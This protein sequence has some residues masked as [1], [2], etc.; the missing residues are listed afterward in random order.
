MTAASAR[1]PDLSGL[2]DEELVRR[3]RAGETGAFAAVMQR[4]NQRLYRVARAM[5][6]D[7]GE[8]ED[9][10][11]AAYL[12]AFA[13]LPGFRG[14]AAL[15]TWLTRIVLN[16]AFGRV[17]GRR[18]TDEL[19]VLETQD[20]D[21]RARLIMF[22]GV[23]VPADPEAAAAQAEIRRLL[24][25]AIDTL[26]DPFRLVFVMRELE[27]MSVEETSAQLGIRPETVKTR[28]HR[29]RRLLRAE[30]DGRLSSA[31]SGTFPFAG[32]RCALIIGA[33]LAR[34]E[35]SAAAGHQLPRRSAEPVS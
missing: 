29:A 2:S 12:R 3:I 24:E 4:Y 26:P 7:D 28:L 6:R 8:A 22:P 14:E 5:V 18:P 19:V 30:L 11:Q 31:L 33:V 23:N 15:G 25:N 1:R 27:E 13:A 21:A 16:E 32:A 35:A 17:R 20:R 34:L 10:V 9:V